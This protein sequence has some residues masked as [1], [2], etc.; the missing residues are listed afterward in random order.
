MSKRIIFISSY[1]K[2]GNTWVRAIVSAIL[3]NGNVN[4]NEMGNF[5]NL[6]SQQAHFLPFEN[7]K[8]QE[9]GNLDFK[10]VTDNWINAQ[11]RINMLKKEAVFYKTHNVRG[12]INK[13]YFTD[14]TT[15][16]GFIHI[17]RDPRDV[18]ISFAKHQGFSIDEAIETMLFNN[19]FVTSVDKVNEAVCTWKNNVESWIAFTSVPRLIIKYEE[20]LNNPRK[21]LSQIIDFLKILAN[22]DISTSDLFLD[23]ILKVTKFDNLKKLEKNDGFV[24][25]S[26]FTNF[27]RKGK[28]MQWKNILTKNQIQLIEK[29]LSNPMKKIG[30]IT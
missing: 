6:F 15:C 24:E 7:C 3:N 21:I 30:Y 9:N 13:K 10:F 18:A 1:P 27:F 23:K 26:K 12:I 11:E 5:V 2:S 14:E 8:I 29:E 25:A 19:E 16:L 28:S 20:M 4:L 17:L 22:K